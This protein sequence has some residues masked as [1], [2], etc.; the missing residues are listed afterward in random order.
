MQ[1]LDALYI[2][3]FIVFYCIRR[4]IVKENDKLRK[5]RKEKYREQNDW[6]I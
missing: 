6:T 1:I 4:E 3:L 5:E 2:I